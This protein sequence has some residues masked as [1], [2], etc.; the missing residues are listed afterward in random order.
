MAG[1]SFLVWLIS[2]LQVADDNQIDIDLIWDGTVCG[3]AT[4]GAILKH[5][6]YPHSNGGIFPSL[7]RRHMWKLRQIILLNHSSMVSYI[8]FRAGSMNS[9]MV[10]SKGS[11]YINEI[12]D[13]IVG[14]NTSKY[15]LGS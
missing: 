10:F 3:H 14:I 5:I 6:N 1:D 15:F 12:A 13:S 9:S 7:D 4:A 11:W 2:T 8:F